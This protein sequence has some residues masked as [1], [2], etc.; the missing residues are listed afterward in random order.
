MNNIFLFSLFFIPSVRCIVYAIKQEE[1]NAYISLLSSL[2]CGNVERCRKNENIVASQSTQALCPMVTEEFQC[3]GMGSITKLA[4]PGYGLTGFLS[5]DVLTL[6]ALTSLSLNQ[7]VL[8]RFESVRCLILVFYV[9]NSVNYLCVAT[10]QIYRVCQ[11][12]SSFV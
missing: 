2:G 6:S 11:S 10:C 12:C 4:L 8:N 1:S 7:N 9:L 5:D 3:D